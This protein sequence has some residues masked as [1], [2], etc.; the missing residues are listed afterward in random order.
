MTDISIIIPTLN[1][2]EDLKNCLI[3]LVRQ[4]FASN[5]Y[6]ILVVDNGSTDS[7]KEITEEAIALFPRHRI[8]YIYEPEPGLLS[9]R[10]RGASETQG[11]ILIFIDD[12]IEADKNWLASIH[13]SFQD[14]SVQLVGGRNLPK[15]ETNPP[16][17]LDWFWIDHPYGKIC[18]ELSLLDFGEDIK[19]IDAN[20]VWG[21]N[22]SIRRQAILK[23]GGFHPDCIPQRLQH[24]QGDGET[25]LTIKANKLGYKAVY[26]PKA[27]VWHQVT[28]QRMTYQYFERRYFYQGVCD[29]YTEIRQ[30]GYLPRQST[31]AQLKQVI[32]YPLKQIKNQ[33][34]SLFSPTEKRNQQALRSQLGQSYQ[35]GHEFHRKSVIKNPELLEWITKPDY[36]DYQLPKFTLV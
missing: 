3:S 17:W 10:H 36:W 8:S 31:I 20:Y 16:E 18:G 14:D 24:F 28:I 1:R 23:L 12:D 32:K 29:S 5:Q 26:Q 25:G 7:T 4:D 2:Q 9:G 19:E 34:F 35:L 13:T 15:Y 11:D 27:L 22:F 30:Q 6:E 33:M 21:L